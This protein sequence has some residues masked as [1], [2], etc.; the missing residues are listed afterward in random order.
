MR[1]GIFCIDQLSVQS[2]A[3]GAA[4][5]PDWP[6]GAQ[7]WGRPI[8]VV[9]RFLQLRFA[10]VQP[11]QLGADFGKLVCKTRC[12]HLTLRFMI[13]AVIGCAEVV[14]EPL[15]NEHGRYFFLT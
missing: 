10:L 5:P 12:V 13:S 9:Q 14:N 4:D 7:G 2:A 6:A 15:P 3:E 11:H 1:S 8:S